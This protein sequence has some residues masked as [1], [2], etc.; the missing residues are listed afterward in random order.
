MLYHFKLLCIFVCLVSQAW[1]VHAQESPHALI[2]QNDPAAKT[3]WKLTS[4]SGFVLVKHENKDAQETLSVQELKIT[5]KAGKLYCN[6][7]KVSTERLLIL[8]VSGFLR[9][10]ESEYTGSVM[11]TR[12]NGHF[13]LIHSDTV[14][15]DSN[16]PEKDLPSHKNSIKASKKKARDCVVRVMLDEK[17]ELRSEPWVLQSAQGFIVSDPSDNANKKQLAHSKLVITVKRDNMIY[18]NGKPYFENQILIQPRSQTTT[19]NGHDYKGP[20]WIVVDGNSVK[21]INCIGLEDYVE[22]VLCTETWPGWPLEVNK[23]CA[24]ASRTYVIAMVQRAKANNALYHVRNTNKH[25]TYRGGNASDVIKKAIKETEGVFLTYKNQPITAMF[26]SCCGGII[27]AKMSGIDFVSS[28]YLARTYPCTYCKNSKMY[29]WQARYKVQDFMDALKND[30]IVIRRI[31]DIHISKKD[32]AG[33]VQELIIKGATHHHHISGKKIYSLFNKQIKSLS[34]SVEKKGETIIFNGRGLGH[35]IGLCQW[36]A[37]EMVR[38][39]FDYKSI[40]AFYYPGTQL[41]RLINN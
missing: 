41:M 39:N 14:E 36:G 1:H 26:D 24:I 12:T 34:F 29:S 18:L 10:G 7:K 11:V 16:L 22:S 32:K 15:L 2:A 40:L 4:P 17:D 23:V 9:I 6:G 21:I 8:P 27:P 20:M 37:R 13:A 31:R 19:F 35:Q 5:I 25:Q 38:L 33:I 28:P 3:T 30:D